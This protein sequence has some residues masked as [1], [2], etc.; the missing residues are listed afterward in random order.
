MR[1]LAQRLIQ[2]KK[3]LMNLLRANMATAQ[4]AFVK[5][6]CHKPHYQLLASFKNTVKV[7]IDDTKRTIAASL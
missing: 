6:S 3:R 5:R 4:S 2:D 1:W 7:V